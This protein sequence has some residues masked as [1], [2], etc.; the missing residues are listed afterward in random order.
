MSI[1]Y[2]TD[3]NNHYDNMAAQADNDH[4]KWEAKIDSECENI[5]LETFT[6]A[7]MNAEP[8]DY[9][10]LFDA[11]SITI[12]DPRDELDKLLRNYV[13]HLNPEF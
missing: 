9:S 4:K 1:C 8:E 3:C 5:D 6:E 13:I 12:K 2:A 7:L 10:G 11:M